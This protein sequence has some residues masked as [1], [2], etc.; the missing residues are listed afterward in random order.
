MRVRL[1]AASLIII[2]LI[3]GLVSLINGSTDTG[4]IS[5]TDSGNLEQEGRPAI[6]WR[7]VLAA[8]LKPHLMEGQ[9][10][11]LLNL[12]AN[13]QPYDNDQ[14]EEV[15]LTYSLRDDLKDKAAAVLKS[16]KPDF[17]AVVLM[18][19][20]T[21]RI[22]AL[23]QYVKSG[24]SDF[25]PFFSHSLPAA[26]I[27]KIV[28]ATAAI[29]KYKL[30]PDSTVNF[31]GGHYTLYKRNVVGPQNSRWSRKVTLREAFAKS[32][33]TAFGRLAIEH[34]EAQDLIEY[35]QRFGFNRPI[36]SE[37]S[38]PMATTQ[39]PEDV[40]DY[41]LAEIASGFNKTTV[42]SAVQGAMIASAI[43]NDGKLM[44]PSLVDRITNQAGEVIFE[45][46]P[47]EIGPVFSAESA[48]QIRELMQATV[49]IGTSRKAFHPFRRRRILN[50]LDMGGKTG[51]LTSPSPRGKLDWFVGYIQDSNHKSIAISVVTV[52]EKYWTVKSATVA[53]QIFAKY[54]AYDPVMKSNRRRSA[55]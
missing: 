53:Q 24:S 23:A 13:S 16:Y 22:L 51:S 26:S 44:V 11:V 6:Q 46:A 33:N 21:G 28:T 34:L 19:P 29:D 52:H 14:P 41:Q 38:V 35:A 25:K 1:L 54:I 30:G 40:S 45:N 27:F 49:E 47:L 36:P 32:Y 50:S 4:A 10:P 42:M 18:E 31:L 48:S 12:P 37:L 3:L 15:N 39:I 8:Q 9:F 2:G 5:E 7:E 20:D 17:A 55:D 43:A